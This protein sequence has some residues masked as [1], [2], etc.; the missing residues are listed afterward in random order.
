[1]NIKETAQKY[2]D[3]IVEMRHTDNHTLARNR[4]YFAI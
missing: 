1:M 2:N 4:A 3:Y